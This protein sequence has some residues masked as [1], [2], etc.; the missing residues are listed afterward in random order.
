MAQKGIVTGK[1]T[2]IHNTPLAGVTI[3]LEDTNFGVATN[4]DGIFNLK[5]IPLGNYTLEA[6]YIGFKTV[7]Q[8]ISVTN[9]QPEQLIV[10]LEETSEELSA[11][12]LNGKSVQTQI[13]EQPYAVKAVAV[14]EL[15]NTASD[16]Q[17]VLNRVEG[18]K[19]RQ[20]GGL[21]SNAEFLLYG[22]SGNQIKFFIDGIPMDN[23]SASLGLN[24]IP[25][26]SIERVEVYN[27]VVPVS[28][29]T[30]ALGGAVNIITNQKNNYFDASYTIGSFNTH[31]VSLNGAYTNKDNG[32]TVRG[33]LNANYADN[34]YKVLADITDVNGNVESSQWVK[35]FH[36]R[37]KSA[38]L[39]LETGVVNKSYADQLL[40][41]IIASGDDKQVQTGATMA[42][43]YGGIVRKSESVIPTLKYKKKDL[44]TD[45]FDASLY[46][47]YN[48]SKTQN[49][50]TLSGIRYNWL[51]E[52]LETG[53][54]NG[55]QGDRNDETLTDNEFTSQLNLGYQQNKKH[56]LAFN[57]AYQYF[58]REVYDALDPDKI[59]NQFPKAY[60]KHILGASYTLQPFEKWTSTLFGKG[61]FLKVKTEKEYNATSTDAYVGEFTND[62]TAFGYGLATTYHLT[63]NLQLKAS[64]EHTYRMPTPEEIFGDNLFVSANPDLGPEESDNFNF[65]IASSFQ[66]GKDQQLKIG[67]SFI[68][69]NAEN[70]IYQVVT[71]SSPQTNYSNLAK[72]KTL[73]YAGN[74]SYTY[75]DFLKL[76]GSITYQ[77]ITDQ[78][79]FVYNDYSGYQT[80]YQKGFR[81][82]NKPYLFGNGNVAFNFKNVGFKQTQLQVQ[83]FYNY[84][85]EYFLSWAEYGS[86]DTKK[87]IPEQSSHDVSIS[88]SLKNGMYNIALECQNL[89][90]QMLFD[91]YKLQKPGRAF[92]LKL[93]YAF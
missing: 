34:N 52:A 23:F 89:T 15:Y 51:G 79:D 86:T 18:I 61:Y 57:H 87:I 16:I 69:R 39:K 6:S 25:V 46:T 62:K 45:G 27:G 81:I 93:R 64:Y 90:D 29:G 40:F 56:S 21:G 14:K 53:S 55:E 77:D 20:Q 11:V 47:A 4:S 59:E 10:V 70:L 12:E 32:F 66:T 36:D 37:Y 75:K 88:Y 63:K 5:N 73:G 33:N 82:P 26:N 28:L 71:V 9:K 43:V 85:H 78:A 24:T 30:D 76:G 50:D 91:Q 83:Y 92:Y 58:H 31:R 13:N 35:R 8:S 42:K 67:G 74:F 38:T 17:G 22:F 60:N 54:S 80:N 44:F 65:N 19:V 72:V 7:T 2:D 68:L 48:T 41:G 3:I 1:V 84:V 49:I